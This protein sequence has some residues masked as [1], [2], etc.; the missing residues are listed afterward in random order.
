MSRFAI[1]KQADLHFVLSGVSV[2]TELRKEAR[3]NIRLDVNVT[4][5]INEICQSDRSSQMLT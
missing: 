4:S 1:R 5:N 3:W 2:C